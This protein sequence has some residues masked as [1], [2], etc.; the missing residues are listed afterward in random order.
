[1]IRPLSL[2][3]TPRTAP[4][5][6]GG[7]M[8]LLATLVLTALT[9]A[10]TDPQP[11]SV[12]TTNNGD[13]DAG[14][15]GTPDADNN[16]NVEDTGNNGIPDIPV[17]DDAANNG[18]EPAC[19]LEDSI[20]PNQLASEAFDAGTDYLAAQLYVCPDTSDWFRFDATAGQ[21]ILVYAE[22]NASFGDLDMYLYAEDSRVRDSAI[23]MS[24]TA[25]QSEFIPFEVPTTGTYFV[26]V[27]SFEGSQNE[28]AM[29]IKVACSS[30][31]DCPTGRSCSL[32]GG[33]CNGAVDVTCGI[34]EGYEPNETTAQA[35]P[36][37]LG[38]SPVELSDL[39]L[40]PADE[41]YYRVTV[42]AQSG[43]EIT[44]THPGDNDVDVLLF[45]ATG[46][47]YGQ[48]TPTATGELLPARF[49]PAGDY[50]ILVDQVDAP[51]ATRTSYSLSVALTTGTCTNDVECAGVPARE[52]CNTTSGACEG[53]TADGTQ[54]LGGS[55]DD[56]GDCTANAAGCY[57]GS[58]GAGDNV[59]TILCDDDQ[60]CAALGASFYCI[61]PETLRGQ[62]LCVD[63]C[64]SDV[65]CSDTFFCDVDSG[66]CESRRC[67]TDVDCRRA[68]EACVYADGGFGLTG[69]CLNY[70]ASQDQTCGVGAAPDAGAN[71][72][73]SR[74]G[75]LA[76]TDG[77]GIF[78]GLSICDADED[79]YAVDVPEA[80]SNLSADVDFSGNGDLDVYILG[81]DGEFYG[82]GTSGD[83]NP[84][85]ALA[86]Y[87]T[88][89]R[90]YIRVT[91]FPAE[92][93]DRTTEYTLTVNI[94][95]ADCRTTMGACDDTSPL[96]IQC[97]EEAGACTPFDGMGA[98]DLGG[99]CDSDDDC[100]EG[101]D[102]C[103]TFLGGGTA[104]ICTIFCTSAA[105]CADIPNTE[106]VQ[107]SRRTAICIDPPN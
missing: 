69:Y 57:E 77:A 24:A 97:S 65:E 86:T 101:A 64:S 90:Y 11:P 54:P 18:F 68:E 37:T 36:L 30:D 1:M 94:T 84:E 71:G 55:C 14:N 28:Y 70:E 38:Q 29:L 50:L 20:A 93:G 75:V 98:V 83:A 21:T 19:S 100:V 32:R 3:A 4:Q 107:V 6:R 45:G 67:V 34:D 5:R 76:L 73:S 53:I 104:N 63:A 102:F 87:L 43:L 10:C 40:C 82:F 92:T 66:R 56:D 74:A 103:F 72:S 17:L 58:V 12:T 105:D 22:F 33:Y 46:G 25:D 31:A 7:F 88:A 47:F 60:G 89:G 91:Q 79:W 16:G 99:S 96:R 44:L 61:F 80:A 23:A 59:C 95:A 35:S 41:D 42:P 85:Q 9:A 52:F 106:C 49:L 48:G 27:A 26:E 8:L 39:K 81:A 51:A 2:Y 15:N 78:E 62:G 13:L